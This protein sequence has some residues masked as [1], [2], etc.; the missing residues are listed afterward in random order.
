MSETCDKCKELEWQ[1]QLLRERIEAGEHREVELQKR[2]KAKAT[3]WEVL[4][5]LKDGN[6]VVQQLRDIQQGP[7]GV[8]III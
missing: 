6:Y 5:K 4:R 3:A 2:I 8:R 1:I 7:N